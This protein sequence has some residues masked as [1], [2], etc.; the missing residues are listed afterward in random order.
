MTEA[1]RYLRGTIR[2]EEDSLTVMATLLTAPVVLTNINPRGSSW[3]V[4]SYDSQ[5]WSKAPIESKDGLQRIHH[6]SF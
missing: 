3:K 1:D 4:D 6:G 5:A 2:L